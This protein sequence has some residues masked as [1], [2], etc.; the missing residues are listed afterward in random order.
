MM[1]LRLHYTSSDRLLDGLELFAALSHSVEAYITR[2]ENK[3]PLPQDRIQKMYDGVASKNA[4]LMFSENPYLIC[5]ILLKSLHFTPSI[6][7]KMSSK[8]SKCRVKVFQ[9][10]IKF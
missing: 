4:Q 9:N 7:L 1:F 8:C 2:M 6:Y 10:E 3:N 5:L